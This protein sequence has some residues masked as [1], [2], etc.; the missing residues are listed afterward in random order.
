[1][2]FHQRRPGKEC[3]QGKAFLF[4]LGGNEGERD[5]AGGGCFPSFLP[6]PRPRLSWP[7]LLLLAPFPF[8]SL[9]FPCCLGL[10]RM[11]A[12]AARWADAVQVCAGRCP[13]PPG[14][15]AGS[16]PTGCCQEGLWHLPEQ[17]CWALPQPWC[18]PVE[19]P[20]LWTTLT[21]PGE[22]LRS[23]T[24]CGCVPHFLP[25]LVALRV[26]SPTWC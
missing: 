10:L 1:M 2:G 6:V 14:M 15:A 12:A 5:P 20:S 8:P 18:C 17:R 4:F 11:P 13:A 7:W 25:G 23:H 16:E 9:P 21:D 19:H 22:M 3:R 26:K 24:S